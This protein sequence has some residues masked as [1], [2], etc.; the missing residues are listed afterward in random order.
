[1]EVISAMKPQERKEM[2]VLL[3]IPHFNGGGNA[4]DLLRLYEI[5]LQAAPDFPDTA[6]EKELVCFQVFGDP[7]I[8]PIK[9]EKLIGELNRFLRTQLLSSRYRSEH[10]E[11][12]QHLDWL[13]W[14]RERGMTDRAA[15]QL[16][17][18]KNQKVGERLESLVHFRT[19]FMIEEE[20]HALKSIQN[21][22]QSDLNIPNLIHYLDAYYKNYR[23]E[24]ENRYLLQQKGAQL[25]NLETAM[26]ALAG[27]E[28]ILLQIAQSINTILKKE[29]PSIAE[30]Q[31]LMQLL[32]S[33]ESVLPFQTL[34]EYL[35]YLRNF[36]TLLIN[37]GHLEFTS[38]LHD[39]HKD[40]LEQG[41]FFINKEISPNVYINLVQIALRVKEYTWSK[42]FTDKY[43]NKIIGNDKDRFFYRFNL[44]HCLFAEGEL[45]KALDQI[46]DVVSSSHYHHTIRR[47][48]IKIYYELQ[49]ELLLFKID[50][51]RKFVVRTAPKTIAANLR[52]MDIN[53]LNIL[54]QLTQLLPKD[55]VRAGRLIDRIGKKELLADRAWLLEK[56][57]ALEM[58][59]S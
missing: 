56:V 1:M 59:K 30:F 20:E 42:E 25:S 45:D 3:S 41:L 11:D 33:Q 13:A 38:L 43:K 22:V 49:S 29:I 16:S 48:E 23:V 35:T 24:L 2:A 5:I 36:C 50:A 9:F 14:M 7:N 31:T 21:Q 12:Q 46:P 15:H 6:L 40:N 39:L 18:Y 10:N 53:F 37:A 28:N 26:Q 51:F 44:A 47:L 57:Q 58:G 27:S 32:R 52:T 19:F 34:A 17:K 8:L 54:T 4:K 55:K